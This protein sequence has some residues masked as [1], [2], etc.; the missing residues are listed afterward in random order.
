MSLE[1]PEERVLNY[2]PYAGDFGM[3]DD[4]ILENRMLVARKEHDCHT[5]GGTIEVGERHRTQVDRFEGE[6]MRNRW[7]AECCEAMAK[8]WDDAGEAICARQDLHR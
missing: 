5:C 7:C 2:D 1:T 6:I 8:S 3:P 4:K